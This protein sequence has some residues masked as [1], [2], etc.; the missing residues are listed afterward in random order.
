MKAAKGDWQAYKQ[1]KDKPQQ[2][3]WRQ[4]LLSNSQWEHHMTTHFESIF[5]QQPAKQVQSELTR[6]D[7]Q[8][9]LA[10]YHP[11]EWAE[12]KEARQGFQR[13]MTKVLPC[14]QQTSMG[15][16]RRTLQTAEPITRLPGHHRVLAQVTTPRYTDRH[17]AH[18]PQRH[19]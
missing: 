10:P 8:C 1:S 12:L 11:V 14:A 16:G 2:L 4:R 19:H 5:K 3:L 9:K 13:S 17:A 7:K 6:M 18:H 15:A